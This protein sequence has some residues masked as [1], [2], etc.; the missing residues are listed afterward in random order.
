MSTTRNDSR[1]ELGRPGEKVRAYLAL[2]RF[3]H[4]IKH[5]FILPGI[6]LALLLRGV[7]HDSLAIS[8]VL[9]LIAAICVASGNYVINEWLDRNSD[10]VH[11]TKSK[12]IAVQYVLDR[13]IVLAEWATFI[14]IGLIS[15]FAAS[16]MMFLIAAAFAAQGIVYNVPPLRT[17]DRTYLDVI[18]ESI[19]NPLRLMIGWTM[20]DPTT[21]PP[22]SVI[23]LYWTGGAFLMT[24]KRLSEFREIATHYGKAL[25]EQYRASFARY[26]EKSLTVSCLGYALYSVFFLAI[27][28]IKYRIEYLL[29]VPVVVILFTQYL[30][31]AME[32]GSSAQKPERLFR[33]PT[34]ILTVS[35]LVVLFL[36]LTFV[37]I[38]AL[39]FLTNQRYISFE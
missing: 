23:L 10:R 4:S 2:A 22:S 18:T 32:T 27:F 19:N 28:L 33:E 21:L 12:R 5:L 6:M 39:D 30:A 13:E 1:G 20:V 34:L 8:I 14:G 17:K 3:D 26:T 9:G 38:P 24:A 16:T 29:A 11:P 31:L 37:R 35:L 7:H 25:L 36:V 15:A